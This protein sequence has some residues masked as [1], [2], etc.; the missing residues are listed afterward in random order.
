M[1]KYIVLVNWTDQGIKNV[2]NSP[3]RVAAVRE[4]GK[5]FGCDMTELY[6]TIGPYDLVTMVEAPDDEALAKFMLSIA[7]AG[8]VR[9]TTMKAFPEDTYRSIV[10]SF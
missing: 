5:T 1:A 9:T 4:V 3:S 10:T 6:M 2:K 7:S 8:N